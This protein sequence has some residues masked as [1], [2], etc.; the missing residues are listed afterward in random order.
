[1]NP[2]LMRVFVKEQPYKPHSLHGFIVSRREVPDI[3]I[4]YGA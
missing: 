3:I 2:L 4:G 1:M